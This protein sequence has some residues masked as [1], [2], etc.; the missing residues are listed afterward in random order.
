MALNRYTYAH[1]R[2]SYLWTMINIEDS[3]C[4]ILKDAIYLE[5]TYL[6][7]PPHTAIDKNT[8]RCP[9]NPT[10]SFFG[11][12]NRISHPT[13]SHISNLVCPLLKNLVGVKSRKVVA[14]EEN[15]TRVRRA[16]RYAEYVPALPGNMRENFANEYLT[17]LC[18]W[19]WV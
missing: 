9:S 8:N 5:S 13:A 2:G 19:K 6:V 17:I 11:R 10:Q 4:R 15:R 7:W 3:P 14:D 12:H 1:F 16:H 18:C